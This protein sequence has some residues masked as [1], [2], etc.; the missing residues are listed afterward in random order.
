MRGFTWWAGLAGV[1]LIGAGLART[2]AER[3]TLMVWVS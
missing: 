2:G 1:S 3:E